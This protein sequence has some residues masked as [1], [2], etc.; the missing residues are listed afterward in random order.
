MMHTG[1]TVFQ[2]HGFICLGGLYLF[3]GR[4]LLFAML[5][6]IALGGVFFCW[7]AGFF[8]L[9]S[10]AG[11][12]VFWMGQD[13]DTI[14][15]FDEFLYLSLHIITITCTYLPMIILSTYLHICLPKRR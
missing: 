5:V 6:C 2:V 3:N 15:R 1:F 4:G 7:L 12:L 9:R 8:L 13:G 11:R 10:L 14:I